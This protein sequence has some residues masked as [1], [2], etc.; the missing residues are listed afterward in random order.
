M[1]EA[2][3]KYNMCGHYGFRMSI[4]SIY[5]NNLISHLKESQIVSHHTFFIQYPE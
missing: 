4:E 3:I 5:V 1:A 2:Y